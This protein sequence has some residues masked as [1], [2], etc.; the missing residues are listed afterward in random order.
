MATPPSTFSINAARPIPHSGSSVGSFHSMHFLAAV[1]PLTAGVIFYGW[2]A[3]WVV[4]LV[5]I[6]T[7]IGVSIWKRVGARGKQLRQSQALWFA[8]LLGLM[9][10]AHLATIIPPG[11]I[12]IGGAAWP[13]LP[14]AG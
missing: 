4:A 2:R 10:P 11:D 5:M 3:A 7:G 6:S 14:A 12:S 1:L 13:I 8:L 9:L